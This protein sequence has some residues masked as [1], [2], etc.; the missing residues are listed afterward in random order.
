L[1]GS[2]SLFGLPLSILPFSLLFHLLS[3][4]ATEEDFS[5]LEN[6][7]TNY[8]KDVSI[9]NALKEKTDLSKALFHHKPLVNILGN[10]LEF[11]PFIYILSGF[12][13]LPF[14]PAD[15]FLD[16]CK[17]K[18]CANVLS[19]L[20]K[21]RHPLI[22]NNSNKV[23][24]LPPLHLQLLRYSEYSG[25]GSLNKNFK[26]LSSNSF[27]SSF[28]MNVDNSKETENTEMLEY[29]YAQNMNIEKDHEH[30]VEN[31]VDLLI[32]LVVGGACKNSKLENNL[33]LPKFVSVSQ[34]MSAAFVKE[35]FATELPRWAVSVATC[36]LVMMN[37]VFILYKQR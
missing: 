16:I 32:L 25:F 23:P 11:I 29:N 19:S 13:S 22:M 26:K 12:I 4:F 6:V 21:R 28:L 10:F 35:L 33:T 14:V 20:L 27:D 37:K 5:N 7:Y 9:V 8:D 36:A 3:E 30:C 17:S 34:L 1:L 31:D 18:I 24:L 15:P 2:T